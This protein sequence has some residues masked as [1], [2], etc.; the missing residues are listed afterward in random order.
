MYEKSG[1][2]YGFTSIEMQREQIKE[3][4]EARKNAEKKHMRKYT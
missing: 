2:K 1:G 4:L 3:K